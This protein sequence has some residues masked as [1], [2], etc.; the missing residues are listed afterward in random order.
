MRC[1]VR[2]NTTNLLDLDADGLDRDLRLASVE[3]GVLAWG[4]PGR[5]ATIDVS[6]GQSHPATSVESLPWLDLKLAP[7]WVPT[8]SN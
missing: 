8:C 2:T 1:I 4:E 5:P 3:L 6:G 7:Y